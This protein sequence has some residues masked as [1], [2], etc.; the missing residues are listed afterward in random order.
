MSLVKE[1][2]CPEMIHLLSNLD[3]TTNCL[4]CKKTNMGLMDKR[5]KESSWERIWGQGEGWLCFTS[6]RL[7]HPRSTNCC[8]GNTRRDE[9]KWIIQMGMHEYE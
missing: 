7:Q 2:G 6:G 1:G 3:D 8:C 5:L 4:A 9:T